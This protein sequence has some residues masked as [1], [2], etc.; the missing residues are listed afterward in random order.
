MFK[1]TFTKNDAK[2][3]LLFTIYFFQVCSPSAPT[4]DAVI[5]YVTV[6]IRV[7][8][9]IKNGFALNNIL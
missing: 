7:V 2:N 9:L 8:K 1:I 4:R 3:M 6:N 5:V